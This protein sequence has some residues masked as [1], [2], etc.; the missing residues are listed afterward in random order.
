MSTLTSQI[1]AD[2]RA[3][4]TK[5]RSDLLWHKERDAIDMQ[6][7]QVRYQGLQLAAD[8]YSESRDYWFQRAKHYHTV[9]QAVYHFW[10]NDPLVFGD[11]A[12]L[13]TAAARHQEI[14][15][16]VRATLESNGGPLP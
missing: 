3:E 4:M 14:M 2:L 13:G 10:A 1:I 5:T 8:Q 15:Q 7:L 6:Q 12:T 9:L 11:D 16:L